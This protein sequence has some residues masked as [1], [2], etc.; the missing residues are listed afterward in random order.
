MAGHTVTF[1]ICRP[2]TE[3]KSISIIPTGENWHLGCTR[4]ANDNDSQSTTNQDED[5]EYDYAADKASFEI[6]FRCEIAGAVAE[7]LILGGQ[8]SLSGNDD[9]GVFGLWGGGISFILTDTDLED[10]GIYD[11]SFYLDLDSIWNEWQDRLIEETK[12]MMLPY[13]DAIKAIAD[14]LVQRK[15]ISGR[16]ARKI[17]NEYSSQK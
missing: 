12:A 2:N 7:Q 13:I 15:T 10:A 11:E 9:L 1:F 4:S 8:W 5:P 17:F 6:T 14:K 3:V 16:L